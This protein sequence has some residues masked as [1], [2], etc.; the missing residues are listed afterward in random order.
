MTHPLA[1]VSDVMSFLT[2]N[3]SIAFSS[4]ERSSAS[5]GILARAQRA[6]R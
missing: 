4:A 2:L 6:R 1:L 3:I 5:V